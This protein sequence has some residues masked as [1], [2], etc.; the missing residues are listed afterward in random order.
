MSIRNPTRS[1]GGFTLIELMIV[2]AIISI[3]AAIAVPNLI[4]AR[5]QANETSAISI[6]RSISTAQAQFQRS[7]Y[8]D[9]NQNGTGEYG[10]FG[11]L[12]GSAG[13]RGGARKTT[14]DLSTS[15]SV[16]T[17]TGEVQR[18]GFVFRMYLPQAAGVGRRENPGGGVAAGVINPT[19][20]EVHWACY[21]Y[22][23]HYGGTAN[24]TFFINERCELITSDDDRYQGVGCAAL[25]AGAALVVGDSSHMTGILAF[26]TRG[27]DGNLWKAIQ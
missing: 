25:V 8:A 22:P 3:V 5:V 11:E 15:M 18:N 2:V 24:R 14:A 20:G 27:A 26:G 1:P 13:V 19:N 9:E 17:S 6:L 12:G 7:A 21:A 10:Y 16:V 4:A 23:S